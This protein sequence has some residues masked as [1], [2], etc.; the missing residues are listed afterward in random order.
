METLVKKLE[1]GAEIEIFLADFVDGHRLYK[2]V[3][4]ELSKYNLAEGTVENLSMVLA[5]SDDIDAALWPCLKKVLYSGHGFEKK[6]IEPD[7]FEKPEIRGD[8][9]EIQKEVLGYNLVPFSKA[10]GSLLI[11]TL[12]RDISSLKQQST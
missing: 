2:S 7:I 12:K 8:L 9:I 1:S 3:A 11:A 6:K 5:A 4:R 10:I